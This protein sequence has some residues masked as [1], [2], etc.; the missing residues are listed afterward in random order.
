MASGSAPSYAQATEMDQRFATMQELLNGIQ[1]TSEQRVAS[2][3]ADTLKALAAL[4]TATAQRMAGLER[5]LAGLSTSMAAA[6]SQA[7]AQATSAMQEAPARAAE[8]AAAAHGAQTEAQQAAAAAASAVQAARAAEAARTAAAATTSVP[9][10]VPVIVQGTSLKHSYPKL[11]FGQNSGKSL[12]MPLDAFIHL[13][14]VAF[15]LNTVP[16]SEKV[17][18]II[19]SATEGGLQVALSDLVRAERVAT[20]EQLCTHLR[21][22]YGEQDVEQKACQQLH[23]LS[24]R[25]IKGLNGKPLSAGQRL[26]AFVRQSRQLHLKAGSSITEDE[27]YRC[28]VEGL[29]WHITEQLMLQ[30][31]AAEAMGRAIPHTFDV[32]SRMALKVWASPTAVEDGSGPAAMDIAAIQ[33]R[34]DVDWEREALAAGWTPPQQRE[35]ASWRKEAI[36]AGWAPPFKPRVNG[37]ASDNEGGWKPRLSHSER[38]RL[39]ED[40][41]CLCCKEKPEDGHHWKDCP[42]NPNN[43]PT[44]DA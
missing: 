12:S 7:V 43:A 42:K 36:A 35:D 39:L 10:T 40:G 29:D 31:S 33:V 37:E 19:T 28:F 23:K 17:G 44:E 30:V 32:L 25:S 2:L 4:K 1:A 38:K 22:T 27:K 6:I 11:A 34:L 26:E 14:A 8:A 20:W 24:M 5:A 21:R 9:A 16:D 3:Q 15:K 18:V 41:R 13:C